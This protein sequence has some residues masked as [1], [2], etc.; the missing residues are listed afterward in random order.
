MYHY[1]EL[2]AGTADLYLELGVDGFL[3]AVG[4]IDYLVLRAEREILPFP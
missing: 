3:I 1:R 4:V 2:G